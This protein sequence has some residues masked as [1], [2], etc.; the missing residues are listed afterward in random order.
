MSAPYEGDSTDPKTPGVTGR[1]TATTDTGFAM[2]IHGTS[3]KGEGVRGETNAKNHAAVVGFNN[4]PIDLKGGEPGNYGVWG[5]SVN[6]HGVHGESQLGYGVWAEGSTGVNAIGHFGW[7]VDA[8]FVVSQSEGPSSAGAVRAM[9]WVGKAVVDVDPPYPAA[10]YGFSGLGK[11]TVGVA[12]TSDAIGSYGVLGRSDLGH[13]VRGLNDI[14]AG[15][16]GTQP[17]RGTGVGGDSANGYGVWGASKNWFGVAGFSQ[18]NNAIHGDSGN[19]DAVVGIA[20]AAGKAGVLGISDNGNGIS[21]IS[22]NGTGVFGS[23]GDR[24]GFFDGNV[25]VTGTHTCKDVFLSG[26]D[27]AEQFDIAHADRVEPGTV[28]ALGENGMLEPSQFAYDKR[29][30]GVVSGAG[31]YRPGIVLDKQ[32][33]Q[34]NRK[35][36]ALIGKVYCKVDAQYGA[37]ETGD[38]LTTSPTPGNAMKA[39][40]QFRAFGAV[41][42]KAL[43]PLREGQ[44]LIPILIALQ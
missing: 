26:A 2:G 27:C 29:V 36:I 42:G 37:V 16:S 39:T 20:H 10:I 19:G 35:P 22:K 13:G 28:M 31:S 38:L 1:N 25:T 33:S 23:G 30:A 24:A 21:G 40:D 6:G 3:D 15:G 14:G 9:A 34:P 12:G 43:R 17:D 18:T 8:T 41:I 44:V 32:D 4:A 7:A 11:S 5:K